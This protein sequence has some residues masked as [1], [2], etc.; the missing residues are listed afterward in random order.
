MKVLCFSS[1]IDSLVISSFV[2]SWTVHNPKT[3]FDVFDLDTCIAKVKE[4]VGIST[5]GLSCKDFISLCDQFP[6]SDV[7]NQNS[8]NDSLGVVEEFS[9]C[10]QSGYEHNDFSVDK[11]FWLDE[12]NPV[13][14]VN[15][16]V[17]YDWGKSYLNT[18][19]LGKCGVDSK[20]D[21]VS[22]IDCVKALL[23]F[24]DEKLSKD[25]IGVYFDSSSMLGTG[26]DFLSS[27]KQSDTSVLLEGNSFAL[28][29]TRLL[30]LFQRFSKDPKAS[31]RLGSGTPLGFLLSVLGNKLV[32]VNDFIY[33]FFDFETKIKEC[34]LVV[35]FEKDLNLLNVDSSMVSVFGRSVSSYGVPFLFVGS[36]ID[37]SRVELNEY[38][39][40]ASYFTDFSVSGMKKLGE[41]LSFTW[42]F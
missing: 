23:S 4:K 2:D 40:D 27:L 25:F 11:V 10:F 8:V 26:K 29:S 42:N 30:N 28:E 41:K 9:C 32:P 19:C 31:V 15:V 24:L 22:E 7:S 13:N 34:D 12:V 6:K 1:G 3:S 37:L 35:L 38:K 33:K 18:L 17:F 16:D 39:I 14:S 36:E 21:C 5:S 20:C